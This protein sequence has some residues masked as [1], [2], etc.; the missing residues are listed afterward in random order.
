MEK[1]AF[2][3]AI[4]F[5]EFRPTRPAEQRPPAVYE[6]WR[7]VTVT[8][9]IGILPVNITFFSVFFNYL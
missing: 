6:Y 8:E 5:C 7:A 2:K 9:R 4:L 1:N 3:G